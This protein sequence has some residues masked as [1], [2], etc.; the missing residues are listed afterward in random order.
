MDLLWKEIRRNPLFWLL[1]FVPA[2]FIVEQVKPEA[3]TLL[4]VLSVLA[5]VPLAG[6]L[7]LATESVASRTGDTVGGLLNSTLGI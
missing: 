2:L 3:G 1:A 7:S 4:F 5:V 6:L